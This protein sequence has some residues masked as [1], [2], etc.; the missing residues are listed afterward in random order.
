MLKKGV[1]FHWDDTSQKEFDSL[2]D[3]LVWASMLYP[4]YYQRD[5]FLYLI[6]IAITVTMVLV[7]E[8]NVGDEHPIYYLSQNLN[9][10]EIKYTHVKKL[11]LVVVQDVQRFHHYIPLRKN[12]VV[13][14]CNP[15][16]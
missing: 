15:M 14:D 10:N 12:V 5:Y 9:D 13:Y 7:Q 16:M 8:G 11:A 2:K 3:V 6:A 1:P 4:P